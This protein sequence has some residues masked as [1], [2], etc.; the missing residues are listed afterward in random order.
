M[1]SI[2]GIQFVSDIGKYLD[3]P[4]FIGRVFYHSKV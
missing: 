2:S 4:M 3:F 1:M